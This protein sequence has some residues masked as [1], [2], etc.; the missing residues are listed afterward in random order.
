M[1]EERFSLWSFVKICF[2][3]AKHQDCAPGGVQHPRRTLRETVQKIGQLTRLRGI[4]GKLHELVG[5]AR[6][7]QIYG[8]SLACAARRATYEFRLRSTHGV[9]GIA[10][11]S[12]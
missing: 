8:V 6:R 7:G 3:A 2:A 11:V 5:V 12:T 4:D 10:C 9:R 1:R